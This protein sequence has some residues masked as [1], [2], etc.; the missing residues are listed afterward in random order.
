MH[1]QFTYFEL[2]DCVEN[3]HKLP[4]T[5]ASLPYY[6]A[7]KR[8]NSFLPK[9]LT[10]LHAEA[11]AVHLE[12][13]PSDSDTAEK[14]QCISAIRA[15]SQGN[16]VTLLN[17]EDD[18]ELP[19]QRLFSPILRFLELP[20]NRHLSELKE[21]V[22]LFHTTFNAAFEKKLS[23][24]VLASVLSML[25][26]AK[27]KKSKNEGLFEYQSDV[28]MLREKMAFV[29]ILNADPVLAKL[30]VDPNYV[31][32]KQ[33]LLQ[34]SKEE[35]SLI[36]NHK[37]A[38]VFLLAGFRVS[39]LDPALSRTIASM[40]ARDPL[41]PLNLQDTLEIDGVIKL[42]ENAKK[43]IG[44][45][46][47]RLLLRLSYEKDEF[48]INDLIWVLR[49][50]NII[51]CRSPITFEAFLNMLRMKRSPYEIA[52][53]ESRKLY[54][55]AREESDAQISYRELSDSYKTP[56][57][58]V[59]LA[60]MP[61]AVALQD[62]FN[63]LEAVDEYGALIK[64]IGYSESA[65]Q[66]LLERTVHNY[67]KASTIDE[68][69]KLEPYIWA[70][71]REQLERTTG[72]FLQS[73]QMIDAHLILNTP[74]QKTVAQIKAGEGQSAIQAIMMAFCVLTTDK[75]QYNVSRSVYLAKRNMG[76]FSGFYRQL[77]LLCTCNISSDSQLN[78]ESFL[79]NIVY[80]TAD[81][82]KL[83]YLMLMKRGLK[84]YFNPSEITVHVND[85]ALLLHDKNRPR[86]DLSFS[87]GISGGNET[88]DLYHDIWQYIW[89]NRTKEHQSPTYSL[90]GFTAYL[91]EK[92]YVT[93]EDV[94]T[95]LHQFTIKQWYEQAINALS[96]EKGVHY[97]IKPSILDGEPRI[98]I[99]GLTA[100]DVWI[101]G[102]HQIISA[103]ESLRVPKQDKINAFVTSN[104]FFNLFS[105]MFVVTN[106]IGGSEKY[107]AEMYSGTCFMSLPRYHPSKARNIGSIVSS[108][109]TAQYSQ[110]ILD[111]QNARDHGQPLLLIFKTIRESTEFHEYAQ[112]CGQMVTLITDN[113]D[114]PTSPGSVVCSTFNACLFDTTPTPEAEA[115][116]GLGVFVCSP[117]DNE[118][119]ILLHF[120]RTGQQGRNGFF[121]FRLERGE[122]LQQINTLD[123][124]NAQERVA[125]QQPH[126]TDTNSI[127][128]SDSRGV[129][130]ALKKENLS[131]GAVLVSRLESKYHYSNEEL[132]QT[133]ARMRKEHQIWKNN[134]D[135]RVATYADM[136]FALQ[137]LVYDFQ[138]P[139]LLL[140]CSNHIE[141]I[142][143]DMNDAYRDK[144]EFLPQL[145]KTFLE[146]VKSAELDIRGLND[147]AK[148]TN[149]VWM[150]KCI[151]QIPP[152]PAVSRDWVYLAGPSF[153]V[154]ASSSASET[155]SSTASA[156]NQP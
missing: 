16:L 75:K 117:P 135:I 139:N 116:G 113:G 10:I 32:T 56:S 43:N 115:N 103:R 1:F 17:S 104:Y 4:I 78:A 46:N 6:D 153:F 76:T 66:F 147:L 99:I 133:W 7:F 58:D 72:V 57:H 48:K 141:M 14:K 67:R 63:N 156:S 111:I 87:N 5:S 19:Y 50:A 38:H 128:A 34:L 53:K 100:I 55:M 15:Q 95:L 90:E 146:M 64:M 112:T 11:E 20:A 118:R 150:V 114:I 8:L 152:I 129:A 106:F 137:K 93:Q 123:S 71:L 140:I 107:L 143:S 44:L 52:I 101:G 69:M 27:L 22:N 131:K 39:E 83:G 149:N 127:S 136:V 45:D 62:S 61:A 21:M 24:V 109:K 91:I 102:L 31:F 145:G 35:Y 23:T 40:E 108:D 41:N 68:K 60:L 126:A 105:S 77:G 79:G 97:Q 73:N 134:E 96:L 110:L 86:T 142:L 42:A 12:P 85:V 51:T 59:E 151:A 36:Q 74:Q 84:A 124:S 25:M 154:A 30:I 65:L 47:L 9:L 88:T 121:A 120:D 3:N 54:S 138:D 89:Q 82:F 29:K 94:I 26:N 18:S 28:N 49:I 144:K 33:Q 130:D 132:L 70:V 148:T 92:K 119:D 37:I 98:E 122:L 80:G 2:L 155:L 81:T 13:M 125:L